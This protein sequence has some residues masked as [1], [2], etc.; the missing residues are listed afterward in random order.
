MSCLVDNVLNVA[1]QKTMLTS[2]DHYQQTVAFMLASI[3]RLYIE[4]HI[5]NIFNYFFLLS[6]KLNKLKLYI[7]HK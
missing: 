1:R 6:Y 2:Q 7:K 3:I 5:F 4:D